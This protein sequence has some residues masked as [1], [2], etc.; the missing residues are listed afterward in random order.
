ML[1]DLNA[2]PFSPLTRDAN[3]ILNSLQRRCLHFLE[4]STSY[5]FAGLHRRFFWRVS[6]FWHPPGGTAGTCYFLLALPRGD[7]FA[8]MVQFSRD[9]CLR[10]IRILVRTW[11]CA[12]TGLLLLTTRAT[13]H[14]L[15]TRH[16]G[17]LAFPAWRAARNMRFALPQKLAHFYHTSFG[18]PYRHG[19]LG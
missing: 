2:T 6:T 9:V 17:R 12:R 15:R 3:G 11:C 5:S 10:D 19:A 4:T 18:M 7:L 14:A 16:G 8:R 1:P 13:F